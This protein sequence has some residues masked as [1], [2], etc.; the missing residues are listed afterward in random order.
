MGSNL[1][2]NIFWCSVT[3]LT[4]C[5]RVIALLSAVGKVIDHTW[6]LYQTYLNLICFNLFLE[7]KIKKNEKYF[8]Q[9]CYLL[10]KYKLLTATYKSYPA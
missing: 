1:T 9:K 5:F 6:A 8:I 2:P 10:F 4:V 3:P 7:N